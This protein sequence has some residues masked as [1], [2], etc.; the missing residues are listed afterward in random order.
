MKGDEIMPQ[1]N[2]QTLNEKVDKNHAETMQRFK[3]QEETLSN[4]IVD[5][6]HMKKHICN[7]DNRVANM[8]NHVANMDN[9]MANMENDIAEIKGLLQNK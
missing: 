4:I 3:N 2:I 6:S 5:I 9:R 1:L 7:V 8:E